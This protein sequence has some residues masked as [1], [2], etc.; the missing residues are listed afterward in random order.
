MQIVTCSGGANTGSLNVIRNGADFQ[1]L[2]SIPGL[3]N[4]TNV[5]SVRNMFDDAYVFSPIPPDPAS[6]F[7]VFIFCFS[8]DA[9]ILVSTLQ[10]SHLFRIDNSGNNTTLSHMQ[11]SGL[12]T[13]QRTLAFGNVMRRLDNGGYS[14]LNSQLVVQVTPEGVLLLDYDMTLDVYEHCGGFKPDNATVVAADVNS[15]QVL[16]ALSNRHLVL[17]SVQQNNTL[18]PMW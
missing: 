12:A 7:L 15:S 10:A 13:N 8:L 16:L 1:E 5:W 11:E 9:Y 18:Q 2:A 6:N 4:I 14:A 17:L 3:S